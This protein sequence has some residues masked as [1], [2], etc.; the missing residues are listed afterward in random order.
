MVDLNEI[1]NAMKEK[2]EGFAADLEHYKD[3]TDCDSIAY[4][5]AEGQALYNERVQNLIA[6][7]KEA[8]E[9]LDNLLETYKGA[10]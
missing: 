3:T 5:G 1:I 2:A 7:H 4:E 9:A 10:W 8:C 6:V